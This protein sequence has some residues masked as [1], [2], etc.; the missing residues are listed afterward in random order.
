MTSTADVYLRL[1]VDAATV[2]KDVDDGL[3]TVDTSK[4]GQQ[5]GASY[6]N[7]FGK[8]LNKQGPAHGQNFAQKVAGGFTLKRAL[9]GSA[10]TAGLASLPALA[11][12]AGILAGVALAGGLVGELI[13]SD[14]KLKAAATNLGKS[15]SKTL[16]EAGKTSGLTAQLTASFAEIQAKVLPNFGR[17]FSAVFRALAP[18]IKPAT[19]ALVTFSGW[20]ADHA[21][22][23]VSGFLDYIKGLKAPVTNLIAQLR[24][25]VWPDIS[26]FLKDMA[27]GAGS[28]IGAFGGLLV[29]ISPL[30][31]AIG[32]M[33]KIAA[34]LL[35]K[36]PQLIPIIL[37]FAVAIKV[38]TAAMALANLV[39]DANPWVLL[40]LAL[41]AVT[42]LVIKYWGPI[43]KFFIDLWNHIYS[44][45]ISPIVNFFTQ[46][47]PHAFDVAIAAI[48][49]TLGTWAPIL[50][51][52]LLG[53]IAG[54]VVLIATHWNTIKNT[55]LDAWHWITANVLTPIR[56]FFTS[57]LPG[58]FDQAVGFVRTHFVTPVQNAFKGAWDWIVSNV[59]NPVHTFFTATIP[60]WFDQAIGF[61]NSR[62]VTPWKNAIKGGWDWIV[63]NVFTPVRNFLTSTLPGE[64]DTAVSKVGQFWAKVQNIVLAPI[65]WVFQHVF[66]PLASGFD[67]VTNA[68]GLGKPIP[69]PVI[70]GWATGGSPGRVFAGTSPTAD[71]VHVRVSRGE[72]IVS[73]AHSAMLAPAF[74]AVGVPGYAGG[75]I[76]LIGGAINAVTGAIGKAIDAGKIGAAIATGNSTALANAIGAMLGNPAGSG[77]A[78]E[79]LKIAT[80]IP[81]T[82]VKDAVKWLLGSG[83]AGTKVP[84]VG[85]GTARWA[86]LVKQA[87]SME[88][89]SASLAANV[90][91]QMQ[92]ESGGNPNAI[93]LTDINAQNGD[94]SKGLLQVIGATFRAF[95]W[96]GTSNNIYDPLANIAAA[97]NYADHTYGPNLANQYGGI[98]SGHG[99]RNGGPISENVYG[100]GANSG[101]RYKFDAG[102]NVQSRD[103]AMASADKLDTLIDLMRTQIKTTAAVPQAVGRHVGGAINGVGSDAAW[104]ARYPTGGW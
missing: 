42:V 65:K 10:V 97:I 12:G 26:K 85:S 93:N 96:P 54:A 41:V 15:F 58:W 34:D 3:K 91:Y 84:N 64:F 63:S 52:L 17:A 46:T 72:T 56:V 14:P 6:G 69:S 104:R 82:L 33:A 88:G 21:S 92:T 102:E 22:K 81:T 62:F 18:L 68:L 76:P 74:G 67:T 80:A 31:P 37:G 40:G 20:I 99:Y 32:Q 39:S 59:W 19:D 98:G 100:F 71:D 73:A 48:K 75:G 5:A 61:V 49:S 77:A 44:G 90:L 16:A 13:K 27:G 25:K 7:E 95:H 70:A 9:I 4:A 38:V 103:A 50:A 53:P 24:D 23:G 43:S 101:D 94:P 60:G 57:T 47:I 30:L 51:T 83:A 78:G 79:M 2:K 28:S 35:Q 66:D 29:A 36:Y 1:R 87:L 45:F 11:A 89:L 86:G 55:F 8:E